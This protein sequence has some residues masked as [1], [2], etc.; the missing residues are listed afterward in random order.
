MSTKSRKPFIFV[1]HDDKIDALSFS[2][3]A[4]FLRCRKQWEYNYLQ[5][6]SPRVEHHSLTIGKLAHIC[7]AAYWRTKAY[8]GN[9]P[10]SENWGIDAIRTAV[11]DSMVIMEDG[12]P[13]EQDFYE[14]I[15]SQAEEVYLRALRA[16]Q[17]DGWE[18]MFAPARE[19]AGPLV[20][21]RFAIPAVMKTPIQGYIDLVAR[22]I[23]TG[24]V[25]QIDW[26][27]VS[28]FSDPDGEMF[29][30]QNALYQYALKRAGVPVVG[31]ITFLTL[32][33]ASTLPKLNKNGTVSRA[34]IR[35]TWEQYAEFVRANGGDPEDYRE[36]M[37]PKLAGIEWVSDIREY[38]N[39]ETLDAI[40][41]TEYIG[42][43]Y[44]IL[45]KKTRHPRN[46]SLMT[47][48]MCQYRSLCHAELRGYDA[49]Y[50]RGE[51]YQNRA[52][53]IPVASSEDSDDA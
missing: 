29:N 16:F 14:E 52:E 33:K 38:R 23:S 10:T 28:A 27:F 4:S 50:V 25:W 37:Q 43:A 47:C 20:E 41:K 15:S 17:P 6:L 21:V 8:N 7:M 32:N 44:E 5:K 39:A 48:R 36:E 45:S 40:W 49:E 11:V 30:M 19:G 46:V 26:K 1:N 42:T 12:D 13:L 31:S 3:I 35:T 18:V 9:K 24:A 34:L 51:E 2:Q 53:P 22:E